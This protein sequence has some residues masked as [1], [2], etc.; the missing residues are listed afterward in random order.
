[1]SIVDEYFKKNTKG[2]GTLGQPF[3][4]TQE[5]V[6]DTSTAIDKILKHLDDALPPV[7]A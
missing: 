1:M 5:F 3:V 6:T 4:V 7:P 2:L